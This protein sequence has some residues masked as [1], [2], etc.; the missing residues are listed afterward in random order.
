MTTRFKQKQVLFVIS[1]ALVTA[2]LIAYEPIRHNNFVTY[3]DNSYIVD[4]PQVKSGIT[5]KSL[6]EAFTKPHFF[7]WHPLTTISHMLDCQIFGLNP[8]G[9][10]FTSLLL[11][12][13]NALLLFWI[14]NSMTGTTWLNAFVAGVFALHPIQV[15]SVAWAAER[16]TVMSGLFWLLT[17]AAY[18][19]YAKQPGFG[20][21]LVVLLVF[22]LCIMTKPVVV[23]LPF[24]LLLLDY[25]PLE[26]IGKVSAGR[27]ITEKIPLLILSAILS[28]ITFIAQHQGGVVVSLGKIS[29]KDRIGNTFTSYISYLSKT[30]WP[31]G[32]AVVYPYRSTSFSDASTVGRIILFVLML[33]L[34]IYIGR[35]RKYVAMGWLWY[36]GTLVPVIGLVQSGS[37]AMANRYMYIP[38]LGLL[39]IVAWGIKDIVNNKRNLQI[40]ATISAGVILTSALILSRTQ[41]RYW[42]DSLT[43]FEHTL[44]ITENNPLAENSYGCA[45]FDSGR[46]NEAIL[47]LSKAVKI[48]PLYIDARNNLGKVFLKEGKLNEAIT[49][50]NEVI[51]QD[52]NLAEAHYNLG[53]ASGRQKRSDEA[54]RTGKNKAEIYTNIGT[55]YTQLGKYNLA[56][57]NWAK[58]TELKPDD[59]ELLNNLAWLLATTSDVSVSDANKAVEL[60]Q[61]ACEL[62]GY[63]NP[64]FLDTLAAAYA[65]AG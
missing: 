32:L 40:V 14:L 16:K 2:T 12:I 55:A 41:V 51:K 56:I 45:L 5:W 33:F 38:I 31:N 21:Y 23:T 22:G 36:I 43:L 13:L 1:I 4:N 42:Q 64:S 53:V 47:H 28:V 34:S 7:M 35:R 17:T 46:V 63:K 48:D 19:R 15:E 30:I 24:T 25:W 44:K 3:D 39:I 59:A 49:C 50:F 62:T 11:H 52:E 65:A 10:H 27:L 26:R 60:A 20:R 9:H 18:I 61:H 29:L 58:A 6:G 54:L 57:E 8:A 37:Q